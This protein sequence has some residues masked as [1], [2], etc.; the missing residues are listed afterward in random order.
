MNK[1]LQTQICYFCLN[2]LNMHSKPSFPSYWKTFLP[3]QDGVQFKS[4]LLNQF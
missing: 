1:M 2:E 3:D 4:Y